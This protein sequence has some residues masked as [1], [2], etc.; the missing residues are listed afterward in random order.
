M[1]EEVLE[2]NVKSYR[3]TRVPFGVISSPSLLAAILKYYLD[4]TA[5]TIRMAQIDKRNTEIYNKEH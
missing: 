4:N 1:G 3:F 5:T 2:E